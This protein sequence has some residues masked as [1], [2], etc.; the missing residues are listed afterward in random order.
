MVS[1]QV[2][3]IKTI[4]L[5]RS[6]SV[7]PMPFSIARAPARSTPSRIWRLMC[8]RSKVPL[9][10][11]PLPLLLPSLMPF[12]SLLVGDC[13]L[14][15][16]HAVARSTGWLAAVSGGAGDCASGRKVMT[17]GTVDPIAD[18]DAYGCDYRRA[19]A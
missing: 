6:S 7:R 18:S 15:V 9:K 1:I 8:R 5:F 19:N 17:A 2:L 4:G 13:A 11:L 12:P 14:V 3:A 16:A 10:A